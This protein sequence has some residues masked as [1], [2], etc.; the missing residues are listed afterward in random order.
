MLW[1]VTNVEFLWVGNGNTW[2][3]YSPT[4]GGEEASL[5]NNISWM[6]F[7]STQGAISAETLSYSSELVT[8]NVNA[9]SLT[10]LYNYNKRADTEFRVILKLSDASGLSGSLS[11]TT[12]EIYFTLMLTTF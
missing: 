1:T 4:I 11:T 2:T 9:T 8:L 3:V 6:L 5:E 12:T 7:T 10:S